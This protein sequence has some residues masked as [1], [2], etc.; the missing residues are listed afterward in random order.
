MSHAREIVQNPWQ[1]Q[2]WEYLGAFRSEQG[3]AGFAGEATRA[4]RSLEEIDM[5]FSR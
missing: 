5:E 3:N 4:V 2:A 1:S